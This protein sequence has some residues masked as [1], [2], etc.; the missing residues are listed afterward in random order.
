MPPL[1]E[2]IDIT[3]LLFQGEFSIDAGE[4]SELDIEVYSRAS[5]EATKLLGT[6]SPIALLRKT[7]ELYK[8]YIQESK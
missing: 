4:E 8:K 6:S 5:E 3:E 7:K 2:N 1:E